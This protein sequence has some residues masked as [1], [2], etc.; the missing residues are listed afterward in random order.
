MRLTE[1]MTIAN[2]LAGCDRTPPDSQVYVDGDVHRVLFGIDVDVGE[3]L[4]A[5]TLG[6]DGVIAHHPVGGQ[7]R[8]GLPLVME[9]HQ[10]QM[11]AEGIPRD[12]A[13]S[14]M[15]ARRRPVEKTLQHGNHDR[16]ADA[17]RKLGI[18]LM[19]IHLAADRIG[20][21][22]FIEFVRRAVAEGATTAGRLVT[23]L[24]TL[25][26]MRASLVKPQL[27]LGEP[28]NPVGRWIVQMAAGTNGGPAVF[29]TYYEH[30]LTTIVA[31]HFE[32]RDLRELERLGR[33]ELNLIITGH[34][35]SD[36][37]GINRVI[38]AI[39]ARGVEVIS[40]SGVIRA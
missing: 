5:K 22:I 15:L 33:P 8:L 7:A 23:A 35:P 14:A 39:E 10:T 34:M 28:E 29:R 17:A 20:R 2:Q 40:G 9:E 18:P 16:V 12:V 25:P 1:I 6:L 32:E 30:G 24:Q 31:M 3:L 27:W 38:T 19:N 13:R 26:E 37:V 36:S 21:G 11:E 4:L